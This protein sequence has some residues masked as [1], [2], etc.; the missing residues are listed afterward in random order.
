MRGILWILLV[1][2]IVFVA[3]AVWHFRPTLEWGF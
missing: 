3:W 1:A 2:L